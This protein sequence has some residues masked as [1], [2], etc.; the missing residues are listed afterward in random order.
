MP[1]LDDY[2]ER[3]ASQN[4]APLENIPDPS[5]GE[6][7]GAALG[8]VID[9]NLSISS[10]LNRDGEF[11]RQKRVQELVD[12][13][14]ITNIEDYWSQPNK[15]Y[16]YNALAI[17]LNL[18]D[19]KTDFELTQERNAMLAKRREYAQDVMERGPGTASFL[20]QATAYVALEPINVLSMPFAGPLTIAKSLGTIATAA[21]TAGNAAIIGGLSELAVQPFVYNHKLEIDSPYGAADAIAAISFAAGG[22]AALGFGIG[23]I[24]GYLKKV[25]GVAE[26]LALQDAHVATAIEYVKRMEETLDAMP[27]RVDFDALKSQLFIDARVEAL[28]LMG[29]KLTRGDSKKIYAEL[30]DLREKLKQAEYPSE[31]K[32]EEF[33]EKLPKKLLRTLAGDTPSRR[34]TRAEKQAADEVSQD[35]AMIQERITRLESELKRSKTGEMAEAD[36][37]RIEQGIL[38]EKY[39]NLLDYAAKQQIQDEVNFLQNTEAFR[40]L[41]QRPV[42]MPEHF[43]PMSPPLVDVPKA[44]VKAL[45]QQALD[46]SGLADEYSKTMAMLAEVKNNPATTRLSVVIDGQEVDI[47]SYIKSVDDEIDGIESVLRCAIG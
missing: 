1:F 20:G 38:P 40:E 24:S 25:R 26:P 14:T 45:E 6:T 46:A 43:E 18:P 41:T 29:Q 34:K 35:V 31:I 7:F 3:V 39:Q 15:S 8:S 33:D 16:N 2:A 27:D 30:K 21:K 4:S 44:P 28:S 23:G 9:E 5:W 47:D 42:L 36:L 22:S 32:I 19:I 13:G 11:E 10:W 17:D 12:D 37:S